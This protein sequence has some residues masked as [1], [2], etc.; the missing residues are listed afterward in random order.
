[1]PVT[2]KNLSGII[3]LIVLLF[4]G[5]IF[6]VFGQ[7]PTDSVSIFLGWTPQFQF[8]GY[9]VAQKMGYYEMEGLHVSF[10]EYNNS[11]G[12]KEVSE[13]KYNYGVATGGQLLGSPERTDITVIAAIFQ[14]SPMVLLTKKSEDI[15]A[16]HHLSGKKVAVGTELKA[17]I[18]S[19]GVN[20]D[21]IE[22]TEPTTYLDAL[23][24]IDAISYYLTDLP[25]KGGQLSREYNVF[26][27]IEYGINFYGESLYTSKKELK[28]NPERVEKILNATL[29]G[30]KYAIEH[31][32]EVID[33]INQMPANTKSK[34]DLQHEAETVI[35]SLILPLHYKIGEMDKGKWL[36]MGNVLTN[37]NVVG[38]FP[39][40]FYD[41][42][43]YDNEEAKQERYINE[44]IQWSWIGGISLLFLVLTSLYFNIQL[45]KM[46]R[47][48][49]KEIEDVNKN[50]EEQ[51]ELLQKQ[52]SELEENSHFKDRMISLISHDVK[53]PLNSFQGL[54]YLIN[55]DALKMHEVKML[56][57]EAGFQIQEMVSFLE[58]L[59]YWTKKQLH[60][61][62]VYK[63]EINLHEISNT[64]LQLFHLTVNSKGI[65]L[66]NKIKP[67]TLVH[68]DNEM[69]KLIFRNLVSN[70]IKFCSKGDRIDIYSEKKENEI[71][72][73][74]EDSGVGMDQKQ[75]DLLFGPD[76]I[77]REGSKQEI[78]TGLGLQMC[79]EFINHND[80]Q[81]G[82][83]SK[84][85]EGSLF[86]FTLPCK[87]SI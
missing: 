52:K 41:S 60:G 39:P 62:Q 16:L 57:S 65:K 78:G 48:R 75:I 73:Y 54:I 46:V 72:V 23:N 4:N 66:K 68:A 47:Y 63:E 3:L 10:P 77:I 19:A 64:T 86:Y 56:M 30:W 21:E 12:I 81:I 11:W 6:S 53:A 84:K 71:T 32:E 87:N 13:S 45:R 80:G 49:T 76:Q 67:D 14:M 20:L 83:S 22:F 8:A 40:D 34:E 35:H 31:Q 18:Q 58:N 15:H 69:I 29:K 85:G 59:I 25:D 42:F 1:M 51:N 61:I 74:V 27:P 17:M 70:A 28:E 50:I 33:W 82:V 37:L 43:I 7:K 38:E 44:L 36:R 2:I 55:H 9:Y 79:K 26:R 5:T 24:H